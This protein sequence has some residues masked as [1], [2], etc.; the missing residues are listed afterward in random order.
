[1]AAFSIKVGF[2][3][4]QYIFGISILFGTT[5]S[6]LSWS[7]PNLCTCDENK[8]LVNCTDRQLIE[9]PA[10][11]SSY[12]RILHLGINKLE[13]ISWKNFENHG[14]L[15]E[16]NIKRNNLQEITDAPFRQL[17]NLTKLVLRHNG[18]RTLSSD[19]FSGLTSLKTLS[20]SYNNLAT[21]PE[22]L[23]TF[24]PNLKILWV[25]SNEITV[26]RP[27]SVNLPKLTRLTLGTN[28]IH[29]IE[30]GTFQNNSRLVFL[31]LRN[32]MLSSITY[33]FMLQSLGNLKHLDLSENNIW[34][35][36]DNAFIYLKKLETLKLDYNPFYSLP[37]NIF[38]DVV[39]LNQLTLR[40]KSM[41]GTAVSGINCTDIWSQVIKRLYS[42]EQIRNN[43]ELIDG[44]RPVTISDSSLNI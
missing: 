27:E 22:N 36:S 28:Q 39:S 18:L 19:C 43:G 4:Y 29:T 32:N 33:E 3:K 6:V 17:R 15:T 16:L 30:R 38:N 37:C 31:D 25:I 44:D 35:I 41:E 34:N 10:N 20:L 9:F 5:L 21:F 8:G 2:L 7:C 12:T 13:N 40:Q 11:V 24:T 23:R 26:I 1:M 14:L 42:I